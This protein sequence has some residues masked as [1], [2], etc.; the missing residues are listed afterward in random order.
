MFAQVE[1]MGKLQLE[2]CLKIKDI[3][4]ANAAISNARFKL[5]IICLDGA[6]QQKYYFGGK[7]EDIEKILYSM[8][9]IQVTERKLSK[10]EKE[11]YKTGEV[12][13]MIQQYSDLIEYYS[14]RDQEKTKKYVGL[15]QELIKKNYEG[16]VE[17]QK[18]LKEMKEDIK[19]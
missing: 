4:E 19:T 13:E 12:N 11:S 5:D 2:Q 1:G 7:Q 17:P 8:N 18:E 14:L 16:E 9:P 10:S 15:V 3:K 6:P